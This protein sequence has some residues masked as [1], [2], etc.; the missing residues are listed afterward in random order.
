MITNFFPIELRQVEFSPQ[1]VAYSDEKLQ[2]LRRAHNS[3]HSFFRVGNYI[4]CIHME[5]SSLEVG[6]PVLV[7]MAD[8]HEV[9]AGVIRHLLFR[10]FVRK[11]PG[12][13]PLD[14]YPLR[15]LSRKIQHDAA[16][17]HLPPD[18]QGILTYTRLNEIQTRTLVSSGKPEFVA[19]INIERHWSLSRN[20]AELIR[21]GFDPVGL[22]VVH[23]VP[24]PG[25]ANLMAPTENA[26]GRATA[27]DGGL[28][29]VE[30][31]NGSIQFKAEECY[32]RRSA[33]EIK[34]YLTHRMTGE[35]AEEVFA[36]IFRSSAV[37]SNAYEYYREIG[38]I[39]DYLAAWEFAS[40]VGFSFRIS[41]APRVAEPSLRLQ[42]SMFRF[43]INPGSA[44]TRPFAGLAKFGPYDAKR[45]SPKK[46]RILV[47]CRPG[48]RAGFSTA[49]AA[50]ENGIP[51]SNY[52]QKGLR[53]FYRLNG[54]DWHI[55]EGDTTNA[56]A[57][58]QRIEAALGSAGG[59][60]FSLA[61][62]EGDED[63]ADSE[64]TANPYYMAKALLMGAGIPVQALLPY[65]T[66]LKGAD[67]GNVLG[68]LA[69]QIY[70][71]LGGT[72]WVLQASADVDH[73]IVVGIGH[74]IERSSE[75]SGASTRHV[76]G[77]T[78]FFSSDGSFLM[79]R[80]CRAVDFDKYFGELLASLR[81]CIAELAGDYGW[82]DGD[83]VRIVF[84]VFKPVR[85][86]EAEVVAALVAEF[87]Q[88]QIRYAFVN[89]IA[90]SP[91]IL[92]EDSPDQD[93]K[94]LGFFVP[95]R[96]ANMVLDD[97]SC[98]VQLRGRRQ[99]KSSRH[100]FSRAALVRIHPQST[101][102]DLH[103]IAQQIADFS[104]L[105]WRSFFPSFIPVTILYANWIAEMLDKLRRVPGWNPLVVN[106]ALRRKKWFL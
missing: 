23:A 97:E 41:K 61:I 83:T 98:L 37:T 102:R 59:S 104:Y 63:S 9:V 88:F 38:E 29:A 32:L 62:L 5:G 54:I 6:E 55:V 80:A 96:M 44:G 34:A 100:G 22:A 74:Y 106:Q 40:P 58:T 24:L 43:D 21:E 66:R 91:L 89:V 49:M 39:A 77:L 82:K 42:E 68:N 103:Y 99:I 93:R 76:V 16:R 20:V 101:F 30:T 86:T 15:F 3:T 35:K 72:P 31:N 105:S 52:F 51:E 64:V 45:F 25:L 70:A 7:R 17:A 79:S 87:T 19:V 26:I 28:V 1:C 13:K 78:T 4:Y 46:P 27:I 73:E 94:P 14:F 48:S 50:L 10:T 47:V 67:L 12:L 53:D 71:K 84:H 56:L 69:L 90:D 81:A 60:P 11:L 85:N 8:A 18:L 95:D 2:E 57:L 33:P 65:R 75:F 92:F 36:Q